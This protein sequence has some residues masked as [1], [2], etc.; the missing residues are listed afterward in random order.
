MFLVLTLTLSSSGLSLAAQRCLEP[1]IEGFGWT[2][3]SAFG[4]NLSMNI[5]KRLR[6]LRQAK[7]LSQG[8]LQRLAGFHRSYTSRVEMGHGVPSLQ[9]LERYAAA[10]DVEMFQLFSGGG[11]G[12]PVPK[13]KGAV[14]KAR[15]EKML[16][17]LF[18]HLSKR[19]RR[20]VL[21]VARDL[22]GR[23][24]EHE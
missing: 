20:Q 14:A 24:G 16:L 3:A 6:E 1:A 9:T 10:L 21:L 11:T 12:S 23:K 15:E 2:P 18:R 17:Q 19:D 5:G 4:N 7:N 22:V 8:D 13:F